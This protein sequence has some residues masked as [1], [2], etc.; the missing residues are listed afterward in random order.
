MPKVTLKDVAKIV[1]LS[2]SCT[3]RALKGRP[4]IPEST[5][6]R[7]REVADEIGYR[8]DPMLAA[9][10]AY[11]QTQKPLSLQGTL[12]FLTTFGAEEDYL[13]SRETGDLLRGARTRAASLGYQVEYFNIGKNKKDHSTASR[14]LRAR[15]IHGLLIRS[16]P[17]ELEDIHLSFEQFICINLFSQPH[18]QNLS[19]V[20]SYHA[21][22]MEMVLQKLL[23]RGCRHP[24]LVLDK[25][26]SQIIH[27]GWWM[28]FNVYSSKFEQTSVYLVE[29]DP[30][31]MGSHKK[32]SSRKAVKALDHW[33]QMRGVDAL[34]Y[35]G[36]SEDRL[37]LSHRSRGNKSDAPLIVCMDLL[38]PDCGVAGIYQDRFR[39]GTGAVDWL[40]SMLISPH[41]EGARIPNALMIPGIWTDGSGR[42]GK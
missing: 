29:D 27:H 31:N 13:A 7:V 24:A 6:R 22:S 9:L 19:T 3:A 14:I 35:S 16:F 42:K 23:Q 36:I 11:R 28:A 17:L 8:P 18:V 25:V 5:C 39:A 33:A 20:S 37:P 30:A 15:G 32:W 21:Q 12:G 40:H 10:A 38:D 4:D 1:G 26:I 41:T 34:I 2:V